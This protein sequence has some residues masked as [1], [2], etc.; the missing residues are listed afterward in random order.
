MTPE[1][2]SQTE[3]A[4]RERNNRTTMLETKRLV[5][6]RWEDSDAGN[7]YEYA[8]DPDVGP[9]AGWPPHQ[10]IEESREVI[11]NVFNG[12]EAY[13][14]CLKTDRKAIGAIEL[15]LNGHTDMID[16]DDECELG[17]WLG[18]PFWGQGII[19]EAAREILRHAFEDL[20][21]TK[22]W[23]GYYDGNT[24]SKRV[25]EKCGFRYQWTTRDVDVPLMNEKRVGHVNCIT[26]EQWREQ[27]AK[28]GK[29]EAPAFQELIFGNPEADTLLIQMVDDHDLEVIESEISYIDK[30]TGGQCFAL[31]AVRVGNWNND[32]SPWP[33]PA[34]FGNEGFGGGAKEALEFVLGKIVP[35]PEVIRSQG[36]ERIFIGGYSLA[37]LFALW[38]GYQTDIFD[39]IAAASPSVWFPHFTEYMRGNEIH[40]DAVYLSLG[41][42]EER[43]RNPVMSRVGDAIREAQN[44]LIASGI[45]CELEWNKGNHF[46]EPDLRTAKAF[47]WLMNR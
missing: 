9:I 18:K 15:K 11:K 12:R 35:T 46:K 34:V 38:A 4:S 44:L 25:Q 39:G 29:T 6:R 28:T 26:S 10:N 30:L 32:L 1:V 14:V 21:M 7:L 47:A 31:K 24:K 40:T 19:P 43:T 8:K 23:C 42:R 13:A 3:V 17:Y 22:V 27:Q 37:A 20:G 45:D 33:A 5:L 2:A 16:R 36:I 41:D